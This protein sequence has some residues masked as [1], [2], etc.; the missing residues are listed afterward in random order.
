MLDEKKQ[1]DDVLFENWNPKHSARPENLISIKLL[2]H[3]I[4]Q[5]EDELHL[6]VEIQINDD[7]DFKFRITSNAE[8]IFF[9]VFRYDSK[10]I[11]HR[12]RHMPLGK[13]MVECPH[14]HR[15]DENGRWFAYRTKIIDEQE[16]AL[17]KPEYALNHF[18]IEGNIEFE[19]VPKL[20]S[21]Q[22][23]IPPDG[24]NPLNEVTF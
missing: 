24:G 5:L 23:T 4:E 3:T 6:T 21:V 12:N 9:P 14:F 13:D 8:E 15:F 22:S 1:C 16:T 2:R 7:A 10:G 20:Q 11:P 19:G 18:C 17:V